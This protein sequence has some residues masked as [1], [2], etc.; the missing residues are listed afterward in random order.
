MLDEAELKRVFHA[1]GQ[2]MLLS[3]DKK[4]AKAFKQIDKGGEGSID[5][6][7][8]LVRRGARARSILAR[9][10]STICQRWRLATD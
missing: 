6:A 7:E 10:G 2:T 4:F 8:L 9:S 5:F 1:M 3:N